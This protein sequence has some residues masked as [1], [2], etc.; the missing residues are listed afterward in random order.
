MLQILKKHVKHFTDAKHDVA[1]YIY[2][3]ADGAVI[4][5]D[6][7]KMVRILDVH[8]EAEHI[9]KTDFKTAVSAEDCARKPNFERLFPS[10]PKAEIEL[11]IAETLKELA[12]VEAAIK[13][14]EVPNEPV[15][16]ISTEE[17][18]FVQGT[19][20]VSESWKGHVQIK[21]HLSKMKFDDVEI[22]FNLTHFIQCLKLLKDFKY[23]FITLA[24]HGPT[25]PMTFQT[26]DE[27]VEMLMLPVRTY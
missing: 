12:A 26:I 24:I 4:A 5:S 22:T 9:R 25:K 13:V 7:I 10:S 20:Y 3:R 19:A 1:K 11:H 23:E 8:T 16:L 18:L 27:A 21:T 15:K 17:G 2:Y 14:S 6:A